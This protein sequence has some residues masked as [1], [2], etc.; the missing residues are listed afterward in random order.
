MGVQYEQELAKRWHDAVQGMD[1]QCN[2]CGKVGVVGIDLIPHLDAG[3]GFPSGST[4]T[5]HSQM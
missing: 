1:W 5:L 4:Y 3:H 2:E